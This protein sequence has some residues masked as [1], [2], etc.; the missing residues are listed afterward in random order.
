MKVTTAWMQGCVSRKFGSMNTS[1]RSRGSLSPTTWVMW[2]AMNNPLR[3]NRR[4]RRRSLSTTSSMSSSVVV[5]VLVGRHRRHQLVPRRPPRPSSHVR[6]RP[7]PRC[8]FQP[9]EKMFLNVSFM[10]MM[11]QNEKCL[12]STPS[13]R[14]MCR[15]SWPRGLLLGDAGGWKASLLER[16]KEDKKKKK[17][18][19][20]EED[21][22]LDFRPRSLVAV[23]Q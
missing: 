21:R 8:A 17:E 22:D 19:E 20:E 16:R 12:K 5:L 13:P 7:P 4:N 14:P 9:Q 10:E 2:R 18:E 11:T 3:T 1:A 15:T 23:F 6:R